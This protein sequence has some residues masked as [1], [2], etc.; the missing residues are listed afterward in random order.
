MEIGDAIA[1]TS[2]ETAEEIGD[3]IDYEAQLEAVRNA[4]SNLSEEKVRLIQAG[5]GIGM[6]KH[7]LAELCEPAGVKTPS[8]VK[9]QLARAIAEVRAAVSYMNLPLA[10]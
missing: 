7:T 6:R 3:R 5:Y 4:L 1:D 2:N 8:A 10:G 9:K